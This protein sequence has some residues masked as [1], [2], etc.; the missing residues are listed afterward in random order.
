MTN[1]LNFTEQDL[2]HIGFEQHIVDSSDK[3]LEFRKL[4]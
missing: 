3:D 1:Q 2:L 4:L